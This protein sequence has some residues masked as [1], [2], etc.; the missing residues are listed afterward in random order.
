MVGGV[1][2]GGLVIRRHHRPAS[3]HGRVANLHHLLSHNAQC[4]DEEH[5][6]IYYT[7]N[8]LYTI[9]IYTICIYTLCTYV[10]ELNYIYIYTIYR[11][12]HN[13]EKHH[14]L[15]HN[16]QY[17]TLWRRE[18]TTHWCV[19]LGTF[20]FWYDLVCSLPFNYCTISCTCANTLM[21]TLIIFHCTS[22]DFFLKYCPKWIALSFHWENMKWKALFLIW[23]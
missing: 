10:Y 12:Q 3:G 17:T 6:C 15:S 7:L 9:Y 13:G 18:H 14:L 2:V 16:V 23:N 1:V 21:H 11:V 5:I 19:F 20:F 8:T 22:S 4:F